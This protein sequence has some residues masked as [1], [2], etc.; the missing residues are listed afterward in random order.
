MNARILIMDE[1][2]AALTESRRDAAV[3]RSCAACAPRGVGIVYISHRLEEIFALADRV[4]VLRDGEYVAT[5]QVADTSEQELITMMVGRGIDQSVSQARQRQIGA[6][7]LE[8]RDLVSPPA[9]PRASASPC[10][11]ARSWAWPAWSAPAAANWR[12][13]CSA[14]R[15]RDIGRDPARRRNGPDHQRRPSQRARASPTCPRI[16]ARRA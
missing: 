11:R 10:G 9:R 2:T 8:V 14:S 1:P 7:V 12:R 4:T 16:A 3:R 5:R 15:P 6:P 13:P